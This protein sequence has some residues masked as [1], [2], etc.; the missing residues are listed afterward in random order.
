MPP[1]NEIDI[2]T[3]EDEAVARLQQYIQLDTVNPPGNEH[4]GVEFFAA[5][6]EAEG[7]PCE[8]EESA[9]GRGNIWAKLEGGSEPGIVL[10]SHMDVVP[11]DEN[12]WSHP[13]LSGDIVDGHIRG[14][15]T[16]DMKGIGITNLQAFLGLHR[17]GRPLNRDVIFVA[18]ADEEA[19]GFY[20]AGWMA[21][22]KKDVF[23]GVGLL[24]NEGGGGQLRDGK[25]S[26]G[27]EVTQKVPYW[28]RLKASGSPG[29]AAAPGAVSAVTRLVQAL[30]RIHEYPMPPK[31]SPAVDTYFKAMSPH[32]DSPW[33]EAFEN[34][35]DA[36]KDPAFINNLLEYNRGFHSI[37][38]NT[39]SITRLEGSSKIN[40]I[41]TTAYAEIDC[42]LVPSQDP[43]EFLD[44]LRL[45]INDPKIELETIMGF[46]PAES[47]TDTDLYRAIEE[48]CHRHY[49]DAPVAPS[50]MTGFTDSHFFR[51][52]GITCYGFWPNVVPAKEMAGIHGNDERVSVENIKLA[53]RLLLEI[54]Q[55]VVH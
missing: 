49:P 10:L 21:E 47:D 7:I 43:E 28:V 24:L 15:G 54:L 1:E 39:C 12:L 48:V 13:P 35:E 52:I 30:S 51:D 6:F 27:I 22:K 23:D 17:M 32:V 34:I 53:T 18:T 38:R 14:R 8:T 19:G 50:V 3:L 29:H 46:T 45:I 44:T 41:P 26:F 36:A 4:L 31:I 2:A 33:K 16:L 37:I 25:V 20:G 40:V 55:E 42:R 9:P 11:F 5:I